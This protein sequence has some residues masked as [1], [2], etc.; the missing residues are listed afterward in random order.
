MDEVLTRGIPLSGLVKEPAD[1]T[2]D[3]DAQRGRPRLIP[4]ASSGADPGRTG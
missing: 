3:I 1:R 4:G 2:D